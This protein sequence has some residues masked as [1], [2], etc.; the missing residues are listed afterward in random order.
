MERHGLHSELTYRIS[1]FPGVCHAKDLLDDQFVSGPAE[2]EVGEPHDKER[3][4]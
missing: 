3:K 2:E 4:S 1:K